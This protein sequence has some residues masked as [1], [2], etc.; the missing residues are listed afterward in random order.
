LKFVLLFIE[1]AKNILQR[2]E[3]PHAVGWFALRARELRPTQ[4]H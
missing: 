2:G 4:R 3:I 1:E